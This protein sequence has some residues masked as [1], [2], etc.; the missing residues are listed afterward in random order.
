MAVLKPMHFDEKIVELQDERHDPYF[1]EKAH[2]AIDNYW[3]NAHYAPS[4]DG[5]SCQ[6]PMPVNLTSPGAKSSKF[7][8]ELDRLDETLNDQGLDGKEIE[9]VSDDEIM[10]NVFSDVIVAGHKTDD[11]DVFDTVTDYSHFSDVLKDPSRADFWGCAEWGRKNSAHSLQRRNFG[12][13]TKGC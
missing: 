5:I 4:P 2:S 9:K 1:E 8:T 3:K 13:R 7:S 12:N 6:T 11:A 10:Q